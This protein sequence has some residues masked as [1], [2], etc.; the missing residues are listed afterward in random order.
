MLLLAFLMFALCLS[1]FAL[2][3]QLY[4]VRSHELV[5]TLTHPYDA[6]WLYGCAFQPGNL[7][8]IV[9]CGAK[10]SSLK[11]VERAAG[12]ATAKFVAPRTL[13][14]LDMPS[15]GNIAAT[16]GVAGQLYLFDL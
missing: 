9:T 16:G 10:E 15:T 12:S 14:T 2:C 1:G 7:G 6:S 11:F 8:R 4:D 5:E 13:Y 3:Q